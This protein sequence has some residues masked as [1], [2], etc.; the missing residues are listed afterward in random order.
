[1]PSLTS[2]QETRRIAKK[3]VELLDILTT[4][5]LALTGDQM[6]FNAI[7]SETGTFL[8][9]KVIAAGVSLGGRRRANP[10]EEVRYMFVPEEAPEDA[11]EVEEQEEQM[12]DNAQPDDFPQQPEYTLGDR[13][14]TALE[15]ALLADARLNHVFRVAAR[16]LAE[17]Q[18]RHQD[19]QH[20]RQEDVPQFQALFDSM[21]QQRPA[22]KRP[23]EE[24]PQPTRERPAKRRIAQPARRRQPAKSPSDYPDFESFYIAASESEEEEER[25]KKRSRR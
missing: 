21:F 4:G 14:E 22:A 20:D 24:A 6:E 3:A 2:G 19:D 1:M 8:L 18:T 10:L 15:L 5:G 7:R 12:Q 9:A 13:D 23:R 11:P 17:P 16:T 25:P